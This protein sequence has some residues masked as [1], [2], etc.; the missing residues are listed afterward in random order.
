MAEIR[1]INRNDLRDLLATDDLRKGHMLIV[2]WPRLR[3]KKDKTTGEVVEPAGTI[4]ARRLI[5]RT[6]WDTATKTYTPKGGIMFNV[7]S[8]EK[9]AEIRQPNNLYLFLSIEGKT[10]PHDETDHPVNVPLKHVVSIKDTH[11]DILYRVVE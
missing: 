4:I 2:S 3:D 11:T 9:A 1:T 5:L 7:E 6:S 10:H 8:Q